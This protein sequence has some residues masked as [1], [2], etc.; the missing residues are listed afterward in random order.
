MMQV[1][2][3]SLALVLAAACSEPPKPPTEPRK[4]ASAMDDPLRAFDRHPTAMVTIRFG[5]EHFGNGEITLAVRGDGAVSVDQRAAGAV[6][7][8]SAQLDAGRTIALGRALAD[9]QFT[10]PRT[11]TLP[12]DP[13]DT[14]LVLQLSGSGVPAFETAIWYADRFKDRDLDAILRL[15]DDLLYTASG[16]KLGQPL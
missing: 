4:E 10:A 14:R 16:G 15:A 3:A 5:T 2:A 9:H 8:Y 1:L 7:H 12:R 6:T 13:G 11:S